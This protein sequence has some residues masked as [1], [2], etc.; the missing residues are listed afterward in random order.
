MR[1]LGNR[2]MV[3]VLAGGALFCS[4]ALDATALPLVLGRPNPTAP[5][6]QITYPVSAGNPQ[7]QAATPIA[8][9][10]LFSH[11]NDG[12]SELPVFSFLSTRV[13]SVAG[14]LP[15]RLAASPV[16]NP[17]PTPGTLW[18]IAA[19]ALGMLAGLGRRK[20]AAR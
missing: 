15:D 6:S 10:N 17:I 9:L 1:L 14:L 5:G 16:V 4:A 2:M 8:N 19:G 13:F 12:A 7:A 11:F 20:S 3:M 18:L